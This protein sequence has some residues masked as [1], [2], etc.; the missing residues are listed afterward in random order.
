MA[1]DTEVILDVLRY[2][3]INPD[4]VDGSGLKGE[5]PGVGEIE[6]G[7]TVYS[8]SIEEV[9]REYEEDNDFRN[10]REDSQIRDWQYEID[11]IIRDIREV[12]RITEEVKESAPIEPFCAW[13]CP[14]HFYGS[15]WGIYI[16]QEC[17]LA[18]ATR[19]AR[20]IDWPLVKCAPSSIY[21]QLIRSAFYILFLHEQF[22]HKVESLG[23]R[24]L[25]ST[26]SDRYRPYKKNV[27]RRHYLTSDC[28]EESLA[29]ADSYRRLN[30]GRM[31][32]KLDDAIK[33]GLKIYLKNSFLSQPPGY[34]EG[35]DHTSEGSF[36]SG[37]YLLQSQVLD[38]MLNPTT[39]PNHWK[40]APNM[41]TALENIK[42]DIFIILPHGAQPVFNPTWI[43]PGFT[44]SSHQ[45]EDWCSHRHGFQR[46]AGGKGSHVKVKKDGKS[47]II[48]G[49]KKV[50]SPGI[51]KSALATIGGYSQAKVQDVLA[52]IIRGKR[53]LP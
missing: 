53:R 42:S 11:S 36:R 48:P 39:P 43:A 51:V 49:N 14:I 19:I 5:L 38:G 50:L 26:G 30:E 7:E 21:K 37:L 4:D 29:N 35:Y 16:R 12:G 9:F 40:V 18:L 28:L 3:G 1:I 23:L 33:R 25:V 24:Y 15:G 52:D 45:L 10:N 17:I 2:Y 34:R 20:Q 41:I 22:H 6:E 13:Y 31:K 32:G 8:T 47:I 27:Y 46:V 44:V